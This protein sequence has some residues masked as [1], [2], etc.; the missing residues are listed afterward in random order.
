MNCV[1]FFQRCCR[2][3]GEPGE[4]NKVCNSLNFLCQF[5][6]ITFYD[7]LALAIT[8]IWLGKKRNSVLLCA[9][10]ML[11]NFVIN[12]HIFFVVY[13][14]KFSLHLFTLQGSKNHEW[15]ICEKTRLKVSI[16]RARQNCQIWLGQNWKL[17]QNGQN[18]T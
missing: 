3:C 6:C 11:T 10:C 7:L 12:H 16:Y 18:R 5:S 8:I 2:K 13:G 14:E 15:I 9:W 4:E 17:G 1:S